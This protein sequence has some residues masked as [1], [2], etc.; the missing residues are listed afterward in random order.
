[1]RQQKNV[2]DKIKYNPDYHVYRMQKDFQDRVRQLAE[3]QIR[4]TIFLDQ[5]AY[6]ENLD[7]I[8]SRY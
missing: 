5:L 4:E 6:E 3:K 2:L 7:I 1:M 8:K